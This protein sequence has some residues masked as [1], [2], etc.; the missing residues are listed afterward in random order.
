MLLGQL[1]VLHIETTITDKYCKACPHRDKITSPINLGTK[2]D[3]IDEM[4]KEYA[5]YLAGVKMLCVE[6]SS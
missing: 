6:R 3:F 2:T 4:N 1:H 5:M